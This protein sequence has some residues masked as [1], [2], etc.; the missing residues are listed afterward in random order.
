MVLLVL[1]LVS[2][3]DT[4]VFRK[5]RKSDERSRHLIVVLEAARVSDLAPPTDNLDDVS[6]L[7]Q[8]RR[9]LAL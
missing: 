8:G 9:F 5:V 2:S 3:L 6:A 1:L 4:L 7:E